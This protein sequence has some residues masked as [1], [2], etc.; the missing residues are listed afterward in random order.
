MQLGDYAD[1]FA[2]LNFAFTSKDSSDVPATLTGGVVSVYKSD[3]TATE[4]TSAEA[5]I[6][7][8]LDFDGITGL[9][10]IKIDL[11]A[12]A[13]FVA[14]NDYKVVITTGTVGGA[15][16]VGTVV[17]HFSIENRVA[18]LANGDHGGAATVLTLEKIVI[19]STGNDDAVSITGSGTGH[20]IQTTGGATGHGI[21]ARGG[22]TSGHGAYFF[23]QTQGHGFRVEGSGSA[24]E[25]LFVIGPTA[26]LHCEADGDGPGLSLAG[27]SSGAGMLVTGGLTGAGASFVG[28]GTSGDAIE[29]SVTSG[30]EIDADL[31][32]TG[33]DNVLVDGEK[34]TKAVAIAA[35]GALGDVSGA[36][37][38]TEIFVGIDNSTIRATV[39]VTDVGNRTVVYP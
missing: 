3:D 39:T 36:G 23:A 35:A 22:A 8:S 30:D 26:G 9:N 20:A 14:G 4:K 2:D 10:N 11:S 12:D 5:Y 19:A 21:F 7:L 15:S 25:G 6:A 18:T 28:G 16:R 17:A 29:C 34:L 38:G 37:T 24:I 31:P 13:F 1:N 27:G 33:L 32:A